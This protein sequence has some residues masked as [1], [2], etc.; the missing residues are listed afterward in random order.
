M[1]K[2]SYKKLRGSQNLRQRL[3]LSTLS[4]TPVQVEDIRANDMMPGLRPHE[5][6]LLRLLEKISDDCVVKI[7]E[8]GTKF[9]YKPGIVMGGRHLVHDC[10]VSRAIGYFL[11]PLV[12]LGLFSKKPLS[13]RLKGITN[14][15]K[16]PCVDTFRSATLPLLKQFGVPSEGLE[17]KIESRGAPPHGGGE[18]LLSVP[19]IQSLTAVTWIDEGM[20][21]RIRGVTFSTR[22]SSQFENTMIHAA[23]GIFNR[24]LPDVHIFTDH[25]AGQQAGNSPGYGISLVAETTS[26]C[27]ITAD[28]AVSYARADDGGMEGEKQELVPAEDVGEQIASVLLNEIEQGGVVDTTHQG[29]LFL[30]CALCPQDV[31][32]IRVG[33]LGTHG[34]ETLR[35]IRDFLGVK[36]VIKPDPSTGTV[37][38][39][40]VGSGLKNLSRKSS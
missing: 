14:D 24:L 15:S 38:L 29:L 36:F 9:Q 32:K 2:V 8:T 17:L 25:K 6:S 40:C 27:F 35:L 20:V 1:G 39:K 37:I 31:S 22:V 18:V 28:T 34:I 21:K 33:K 16:D 10:G 3:L 4:A 11:E 7:N 12:V 5:V 13:I 19:I 23:R 30:L 26:G